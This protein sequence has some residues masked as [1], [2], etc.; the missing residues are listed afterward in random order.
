M[1][2]GVAAATSAAAGSTLFDYN[3]KNFLY[4]RK[5][6]QE[7]EYQI[8]DFRI[9][10]AELWREDVRDIIG[11]TSV[12][13]DTYLIVNA[14][15]LGFCVMAFC[16]GRLAVGT[17]T[18]LIGCHTLSLAG[19]FL[20]L[21]MS[22]WL[23]M[24][25]SVTAKSYEVRLLTQHVRLPVP[26]W[27]Q[28]EGAR[29]YGSQYEKV[30]PKQ[31]FRMP[32]AMGTQEQVLG[33]TPA[34]TEGSAASALPA[35]AASAVGE[36]G[37]AGRVAGPAGAEAP[38]DGSP[39]TADLW[40]LE[41]R[42]DRIYELDGTVRTD[43]KQLQHLRLVREAMQYW[44]SYDG[45][46]RVAMSMGTNQLVLALSYYVL[47]YVLISNHAV[48]AAWLT[49]SL[50]M[51]IAAA[52]IRL[53]MSLTSLEYKLAV[54][55]VISGPILTAISAQQWLAQ[56]AVGDLI[57][58]I[59]TPIVYAFHALWLMF[60]LYICKV[61]EQ[62]GGA[63]LPVGFRSVMYIDV[64]GWIK[65][66]VTSTRS[67]TASSPAVPSP[68]AAAAGRPPTPGSGPAL[69]SVRYEQGRP[70]PCRPEELPGAST[71]THG[72][73]GIRR[74][75]FEP[76]T[77]VPREKDAD[78]S[79]DVGYTS[80]MLVSSQR[81][82]HV[83][84]RIFCSA[85]SLIIV[86]WWASGVLVLLQSLGIKTFKVAPILKAPEGGTHSEKLHASL[87]Q[88]I[89]RIS[90]GE[91]L[92]TKWPQRRIDPHGLACSDE[93]DGTLVLSTRFGL[94]SA[95]LDKKDARRVDFHSAPVCDD[96]EGESLQDVALTCKLGQAGKTRA[97]DDCHAL[98]LHRQGQ[99]L[100]A[101]P[102]SEAGNARAGNASALP[103][104][105][106]LAHAWLGAPK[107]GAKQEEVT[108]LTAGHCLQQETGSGNPCAYVQTSGG[109]I[110]ELQKGLASAEEAGDWFPTRIMRSDAPGGALH[111]IGDRH[112]GI[113]QR[114]SQN[115]EVLDPDSGASL[116]LWTMP[117]EKRWA[118][119]CSMGNSLYVVTQG[120][121]PELWRFP[122]PESLRP[123]APEPIRPAKPEVQLVQKAPSRPRMRASAQQSLVADEAE[124]VDRFY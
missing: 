75:D 33:S 50:F 81:P 101:C 95:Q 109:R 41:R 85:T 106:S 8:M 67:S 53:D 3:R 94:L 98:V 116:G 102:L 66:N 16:E 123:A 74:E 64:F 18:W 103:R 38:G 86:L 13:M 58:D 39:E 57:V 11:L 105:A 21:L 32:F 26:S 7:T 14:V 29:T 76:A 27:A 20:Y 59:L 80:P 63:L 88:T 115:L 110:A 23:S 120:R 5:M 2:L 65:K 96:I 79:A 92:A 71:S 62:K 19:A 48:V 43:P 89:S 42:G 77:F 28:L 15:Q 10:Q 52:L 40:G 72:L 114:D 22:V 117:K 73:E 69:Q 37:S 91:R 4:D 30:D 68:M 99:R 45:F 54:V 97:R 35:P 44:Q 107:G 70:V 47:G 31:M 112:L 51:V 1:V 100:S 113:L 61:S 87:L 124:A 93:A 104:T 111:L 90:D 6:R 36:D 83:P 78:K 108:S 119:M 122:V 24:H 82:G 118:A 55:L 49:V 56:Y 60:L 46:A 17:P 9:K 84:W 121:S 12:K 25:A 34:G